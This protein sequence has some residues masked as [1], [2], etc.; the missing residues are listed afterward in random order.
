MYLAPD[1]FCERCN[2][3][4]RWF[5]YRVSLQHP[6]MSEEN[7]KFVF[8]AE[9]VRRLTE[10]DPCVAGHF[11]GFFTPILNLKARRRL[12]SRPGAD[13][14]VQETFLRVFRQLRLNGGL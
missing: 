13:D 9:Y 2:D 11:E 5:T 12:G 3:L 6:S 8:D 10:G 14:A 1:F 7:E 4:N